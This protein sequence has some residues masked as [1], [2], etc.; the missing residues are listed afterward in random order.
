MTFVHETNWSQY[1]NG[2]KWTKGKWEKKWNRINGRE[3]MKAERK[4]TKMKERKI[5]QNEE[6]KQTNILEKRVR[7][8][9]GELQ[10]KKRKRLWKGKER[11]KSTGRDRKKQKGEKSSRVKNEE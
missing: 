7:E 6:L 2:I 3:T 9:W 8:E 1:D 10:P 4:K 5:S 11:W